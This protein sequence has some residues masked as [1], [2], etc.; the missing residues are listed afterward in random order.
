MDN[1]YAIFLFGQI[2]IFTLGESYRKQSNIGLYNNS[3]I[4]SSQDYYQE[5]G[6]GKGI[7]H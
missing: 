7:K 4:I 3:E 1:V 5:Y 2:L 6:H